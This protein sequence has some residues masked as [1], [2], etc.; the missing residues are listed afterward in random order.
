MKV[1]NKIAFN[2]KSSIL[3]PIKNI[4]RHPHKIKMVTMKI[5]RSVI[6]LKELLSVVLYHGHY[7]K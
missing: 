5:T 3:V 6:K 4:P 7:E 1:V 2:H